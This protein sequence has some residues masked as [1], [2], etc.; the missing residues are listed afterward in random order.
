MICRV[1][2]NGA[3]EGGSSTAL[4][5]TNGTNDITLT[6]QGAYT[7]TF[8]HAAITGGTQITYTG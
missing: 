1:I 7:G 6:L 5:F 2:V 4:G 3:T 8:N